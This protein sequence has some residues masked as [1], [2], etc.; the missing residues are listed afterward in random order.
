MS[1]ALAKTL[2]GTLLALL[3]LMRVSGAAAA[4]PG[5]ANYLFIDDGQIDDYAAILDHADIAGVQRIYTWR[6]L[7]PREGRYDFSAI[8]HDL[9]STG[10]HHKGLFIQIQDRFFEAK[11]RNLPAYLLEEPRYGGG[12]ARQA[13]YAGE[14]QPTGSGWVAKQWNPRVRARFQALLHALAMRFDGRVAGINLPESAA[15]LMPREK[16]DGFTCDA[17]FNA[18]LDNMA[19]AGRAFSRSAVVQYVN[20][21]PCE[22]NNDH[23]YMARIFA[24]AASHGIGLGGPDIVPFRKGQMRNSY[25]FFHRYRGK[26]KLVAMAVQEPTLTYT[27][28]QTGKRFTQGEFVEFARDYLGANII[29]WTVSAPWL[30]D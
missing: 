28:P 16:R 27:N 21:W 8:E 17:Y 19:F 23:G 6:A 18:E 14:G 30:R 11:A 24:F 7:E 5:P 4:S 25:P 9:A 29:F 3:M 22:W 2:R 13:D 26:L 20:F 1:F 10:R 12:L 15:D